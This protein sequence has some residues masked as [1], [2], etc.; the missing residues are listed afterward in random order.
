MNKRLLSKVNFLG[1]SLLGLALA[2]CSL[3]EQ[4]QETPTTAPLQFRLRRIESATLGSLNVQALR[5]PED[6]NLTSRSQL[7][8]EYVGGA[9]P[10]RMQLALEVQNPDPQ[11]ATLTGFD[12]EVTLDGK[13]LGGGRAVANLLLPATST[14]VAL[15]FTFELNTH[16]L[17]GN[18][19]LPVLRNFAVGLADRRRRPLRLGLRLRPS[20][21]LADGH[22]V[23]ASTF[24]VLATDS[25]AGAGA[26]GSI[27]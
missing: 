15:P 18:D 16:P 2:Q 17:L 23:R 6:L 9:L 5:E 8:R 22:T 25:V 14:P 4:V 7:I 20:L 10:L 21:Q 26:K 3:G 13:P 19:A 27:Y 12:Y 24:A 11:S 1:I